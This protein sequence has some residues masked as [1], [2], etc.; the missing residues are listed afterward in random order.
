MD[1]PIEESILANCISGGTPIVTVQRV[2]KLHDLSAAVKTAGGVNLFDRP[3]HL[4]GAFPRHGKRTKHGKPQGVVSDEQLE[5][6]EGQAR[7]PGVAERF[8]V[9]RKPG[10]N[11]VRYYCRG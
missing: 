4:G 2:G 3:D 1:D 7:R 8:V 6:R 5:A 10:N 11:F 9:P